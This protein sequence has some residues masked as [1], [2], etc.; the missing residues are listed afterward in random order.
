MPLAQRQQQV[1]GFGSERD[2]FA[3]AQQEVFRRIQAEGAEFI[4]VC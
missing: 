3:V 1:E 2:G 4:D